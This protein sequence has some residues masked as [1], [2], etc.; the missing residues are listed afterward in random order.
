MKRLR[1]MESRSI[2]SS[3]EFTSLKVHCANGTLNINLSSSNFDDDQEFAE[4]LRMANLT[5]LNGDSSSLLLQS[6]IVAS[7]NEVVTALPPTSSASVSTASTLILPPPSDEQKVILNAL[8]RG[9]NV[10]VNAV[11]GAG[12]TTT[13]LLIAQHYKSINKRILLLTY[14]A[15]LK[16]EARRKAKLLDLDN[17]MES[18]SYHSFCNKY[19][20]KC[21]ND[22]MLKPIICSDTPP[23]RSI[24]HYDIIIVDEA[25]DMMP[26]LYAVVRKILRDINATAYSPQFNITGDWRQCIFKVT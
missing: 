2:I 18:H 14:N 7:V 8:N 1:D 3:D 21:Y 6:S 24:C 11:A 16:S 26:F 17:V 9:E 5:T 20:G 25:Q 4:S 22:D 12:K 10:I 19:Y 13:S 15:N 23:I